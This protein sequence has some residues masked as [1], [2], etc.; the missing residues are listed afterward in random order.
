VRVVVV[1]VTDAFQRC[2]MELIRRDHTGLESAICMASDLSC[3]WSRDT[4]QQLDGSSST[5]APSHSETLSSLPLCEDIQDECNET[6]YASNFVPEFAPSQAEA[7]VLCRQEDLLTA[8]Y[9]L[10]CQ[11]M[12]VIMRKL[13]VKSY[14]L[15]SLLSDLNRNGFAYTYDFVYLPMVDCSADAQPRLSRGHAY[16]NFVHPVY[17]QR[18]KECFH[19]Q[20]LGSFNKVSVG[21]APLQGFKANYAHYLPSRVNRTAAP[22][23]QPLFLRKPTEEESAGLV[24]PWPSAGS[25]G[26]RR[27]SADPCSRGLLAR[28]DIDRAVQRQKQQ[29]VGPPALPADWQRQ[30]EQNFEARRK[31]LV[32]FTSLDKMLGSACWQPATLPTPFIQRM[33]L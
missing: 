5:S 7:N 15:E 21:E 11:P 10:S 24:V 32:A 13:P 16:I 31:Q 29:D 20:M 25:R 33:K 12:T 19:G 30:F 4:C 1:A 28:S 8:A 18:F 3:Q 27:A 9:C 22:P 6:D 2:E 14:S 26:R 23:A 17:A